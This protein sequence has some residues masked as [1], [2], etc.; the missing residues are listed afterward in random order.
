MLASP[1]PL[2]WQP[3]WLQQQGLPAA[4]GIAAIAQGLVL[5]G[6]LALLYV[7]AVRAGTPSAT[8]EMW[9]AAQRSETDLSYG[10]LTTM[11]MGVVA[12]FAL[13][14]STWVLTWLAIDGFVRGLDALLNNRRTPSSPLWLFDAVA[15]SIVRFARARL[16]LWRLG[17]PRPPELWLPSDQEVDVLDLYCSRLQPF[18]VDSTL[19]VGNDFF[20]VQQ[21]VLRRRRDR[22]VWHYRALPLVANESLRGQIWPIDPSECVRPEPP[23]RDRTDTAS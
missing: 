22:S 18:D 19:Q 14:P 12:Q 11:G 2:R 1:L 23:A 9:N 13:R 5:G 8:T 21:R 16:L 6:I 3:R 10:M 4:H 20:R 7:E 17:P 15:G